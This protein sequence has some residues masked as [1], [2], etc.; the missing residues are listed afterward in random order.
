MPLLPKETE[1]FPDDLF[2]LPAD[3]AWCVV[4]VRSRQ[5][6]VLART[7]H[8]HGVPFYVPQIE[9]TT[10]RSGRRFV[11]Y[12]PLF[13]GYVFVRG[14][15]EARE[16][17]WRSSLAVS[18]LEVEDQA[19]LAAQLGQIRAL[20]ESGASLTPLEEIVPGT[21]VQI[22]EGAFR[23]YAGIVLRHGR[24]DR[25]VVSVSLIR[26]NVVVEFD[27]AMMERRRQSM[28]Q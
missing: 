21:P 10:R 20:Q 15:V 1:I 27:P 24:A 3:V 17:I 2:S 9:Q 16:V 5:E 25:L 23:G 8:R 14:G 28:A 22:R 18:I 6:K 4:H 11:S 12:L 13:P 19:L 7:L 26:R